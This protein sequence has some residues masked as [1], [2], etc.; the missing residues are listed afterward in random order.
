MT[1]GYKHLVIPLA[2]LLLLSLSGTA[3]AQS[4][5]ARERA[6]ANSAVAQ[7]TAN[8]TAAILKGENRTPK[9]VNTGKT[10]LRRGQALGGTSA[11]IG[12]AAGAAPLALALEDAGPAPES[13]PEP[14]TI[15]TI[16]GALA[17]LYRMRRHLT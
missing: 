13:N 3:R 9:A 14:L 1:Y 7:G 5:T 17:G 8:G 4:A 2:G 10:P 15:I 6:A 12:P 11:D 16:G